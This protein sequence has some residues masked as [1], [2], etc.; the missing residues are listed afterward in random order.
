MY[1]DN[2]GPDGVQG[3]LKARRNVISDDPGFLKVRWAEGCLRQAL[4]AGL[5]GGGKGGVRAGPRGARGD[6]SLGLC[7]AG[8]RLSGSRQTSLPRGPTWPLLVHLCPRVHTP[9]RPK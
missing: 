1:S 4:Q 3:A 9:S 6:C 7:L 8:G 2:Q 5:L